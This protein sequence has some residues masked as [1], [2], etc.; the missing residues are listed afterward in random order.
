MHVHRDGIRS[1][2]FSDQMKGCIPTSRN[3][4]RFKWGLEA[5]SA[6]LLQMRKDIV[7]LDISK[8]LGTLDEDLMDLRTKG[9]QNLRIFF[10][11]YITG[12]L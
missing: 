7:D 2:Y 8:D 4:R 5:M 3:K 1:A 12:Q 6:S 10:E 9:L 11:Q